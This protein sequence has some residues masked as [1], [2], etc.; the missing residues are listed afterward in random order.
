[1]I[2]LPDYFVK[3]IS[4]FP[5]GIRLT[6]M[7]KFQEFPSSGGYRVANLFPMGQIGAGDPLNGGD[8]RYW[9]GAI[10][11]HFR[12]GWANCRCCNELRFFKNE[13]KEHKNAGCGALLE[14]AFKRLRRS[15]DCII[16]TLTTHR[17]VYGLP[18]CCKDCEAEWEYTTST[19]TVLR[20]LIREIKDEQEKAKKK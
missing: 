16:C 4:G 9:C 18:L 6:K 12:K 5:G 14:E 17:K 15:N 19:P 11:S 13:R 2:Q 7:I 8:Y 10:S 20:R 1:M 3:K